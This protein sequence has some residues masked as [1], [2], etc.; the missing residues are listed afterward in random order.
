MSDKYEMINIKTL[1]D[2]GR[3]TYCLVSN[4]IMQSLTT[5]IWFWAFPVA[6]YSYWHSYVD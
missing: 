4:Y 6:I 3:S 2:N 5:I 1:L